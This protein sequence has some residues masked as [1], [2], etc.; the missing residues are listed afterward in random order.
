[1]YSA[2]AQGVSHIQSNVVCQDRTYTIENDE[3]CVISLAD[4]AGSYIH[5]EEGAELITKGICYFLLS[6][7]HSLF[8]NE[9]I[10]SIVKE[11]IIST[12]ASYAI[13]KNYELDDLSSTLLVV[14]VD[15]INNTFISMHIG[16][17]VIGIHKDG[18]LAIYSDSQNGESPNMTFMTTSDNLEQYLRIQCAS[19]EDGVD[20]FILLSDGGAHVLFD[21]KT[22]KFTNNTHIIINHAIN[23]KMSLDL[24]EDF[25]CNYLVPK[26]K[27][28]D[29]CSIAMLVNINPEM[30]EG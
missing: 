13:E 8:T 5:S 22:K 29:D 19:L 11:Q 17:G 7:Y 25:T 16:D 2:Y 14:A 30:S 21:H 20:G 27:V 23:N 6:N 18:Q 26:C 10:T 24:L 9:E 1:M 28:F 12:L 15:K 4:G 3:I